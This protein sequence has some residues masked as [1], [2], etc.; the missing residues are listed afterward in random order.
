MLVSGSVLSSATPGPPMSELQNA[1]MS[2][3]SHCTRM[4][5]SSYKDTCSEELEGVQFGFTWIYCPGERKTGIGS[6]PEHTTGLPRVREVS[7]P[8]SSAGARNSPQEK[9]NRKGYLRWGITRTR[10][11]H[12]M[13][14]FSPRSSNHL[15]NRVRMP[16]SILFRKGT[17]QLGSRPDF[18]ELY[19]T[20][21][22]HPLPCVL[23]IKQVPVAPGSQ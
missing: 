18:R 22:Y 16:A 11:R 20:T 6:N 17:L 23:A 1:T 15:A 3:V 8:T 21:I 2:P 14:P 12:I 13:P 4:P 7:V 10:A 9:R 5:P 19:Y